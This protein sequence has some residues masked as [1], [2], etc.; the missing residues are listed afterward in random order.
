MQNPARPNAIWDDG[1]ALN[2][3]SPR[4]SPGMRILVVYT[5]AFIL[6][7]GATQG[8]ACRLLAHRIRHG[9]AARRAHV[10]YSAPGDPA[11]ARRVHHLLSP[12]DVKLDNSWGLDHGTWSVLTEAP[13][14]LLARTAAPESV[15]CHI[16][17]PELAS[18]LCERIATAPKVTC[19]RGAARRIRS[20]VELQ[21]R[22]PQLLAPYSIS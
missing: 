8:G 13:H 9:W 11:L 22:A 5:G 16:Q 19:V 6:A 15:K 20:S 1:A 14:Q 7:V 10:Q 18:V 12:L 21:A 2:V 3:F 17:I 4:R